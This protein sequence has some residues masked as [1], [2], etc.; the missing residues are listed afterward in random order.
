MIVC[1]DL[2]PIYKEQICCFHCGERESC[3]E[4]CYVE[5]PAECNSRVERYGELTPA[6]E[7]VLPIMLTIRNLAVQKKSIEAREKNMR[8]KLKAAM[9]RF[10]VKSFDN[11]L[12]KVTYIAATTSRTV[13]TAAL[14]KKYPAIAEEC[15]KVSNKSAYIKIEVKDNG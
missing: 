3:P 8:E 2:C 7:K 13:D 12:V 14:K 1:K 15:S 9:E 4:A 5:K 6:E 11:D 10:G